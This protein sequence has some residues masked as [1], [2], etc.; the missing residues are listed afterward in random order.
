MVLDQFL[1][2][3]SGFASVVCDTGPSN[4]QA[5]ERNTG[6]NMNIPDAGIHL[7]SAFRAD[8]LTFVAVSEFFMFVSAMFY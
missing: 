4:T 8:L 1:D 3:S 6:V 7:D 2:G 5:S